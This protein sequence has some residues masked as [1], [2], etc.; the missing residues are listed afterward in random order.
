MDSLLIE[1]NAHIYQETEIS[2]LKSLP[3]FHDRVVVE[4][5]S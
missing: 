5:R 4:R 1:S 2:R 3:I